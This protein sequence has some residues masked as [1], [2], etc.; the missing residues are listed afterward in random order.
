VFTQPSKLRLMQRL[1]A[2]FQGDELQIPDGW[3]INELESFEF[4]YTATGVR[5]E[6]PSGL[7]DD[8]VMAL[9][10]ALYGWDRVQGVVPEAPIGLRFVGDDPNI[11]ADEFPTPGLASVGNFSAQ[12][13]GVW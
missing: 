10:L 2:A 12:L 5:Y 7:H 13:P 1:V 11:T 6:A 3:L 8:G 9:A 4:Q